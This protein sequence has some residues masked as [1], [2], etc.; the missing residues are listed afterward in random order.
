MK[1][2]AFLVLTHTHKPINRGPDAGKIQ[3]VESCE[4]LDNYKNRHI[5]TA[6]IIMD[7]HKRE[8]VKNTYRQ[9]GLT[10]DQVEEH[11]I[12]GYADK[13]KKFL[14]IAGA[15]IPEALTMDKEEVKAELEK[16]A[17]VAKDA[18]TIE[19]VDDEGNEPARKRKQIQKDLIEKTKEEE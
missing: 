19:V 15:E 2:G 5:R 16:Q 1:K 11:I 8:F 10:Y 9:D 7:V 12:K 3:T 18:E 6:T 14:E 13:Y 4:F 17:E